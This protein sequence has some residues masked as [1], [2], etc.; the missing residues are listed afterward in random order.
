MVRPSCVLANYFMIAATLLIPTRLQANIRPGTHSLYYW[1][2]HHS[3]YLPCPRR[4]RKDFHS[5]SG[6]LH[7]SSMNGRLMAL[8]VQLA[9]SQ[10]FIFSVACE[11]SHFQRI[12]KCSEMNVYKSQFLVL[13]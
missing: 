13:S 9:L 10:D 11:S 1:T 3:P 6:Q 5:S 8:H 7:S 4:L 2:L 12:N